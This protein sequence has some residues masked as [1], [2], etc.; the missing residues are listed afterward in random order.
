MITNPIIDGLNEN[1]CVDDVGGIAVNN[2][3]IV[4]MNIY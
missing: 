3:I 2:A 1:K 4:N